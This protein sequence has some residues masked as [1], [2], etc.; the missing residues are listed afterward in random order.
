MFFHNSKTE[1]SLSKKAAPNEA[2]FNNLILLLS[3]LTNWRRRLIDIEP[4][5]CN[6]INNVRKLDKVYRLPDIAIHS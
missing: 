6:L 1:P 2:A 3:L 5:G 4:I